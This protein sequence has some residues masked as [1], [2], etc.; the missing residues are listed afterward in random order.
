MAGENK[1]RHVRNMWDGLRANF[2]QLA[3]R[4]KAAPADDRPRTHGKTSKDKKHAAAGPG[5]DPREAVIPYQYAPLNE[6]AQEI[7]LLT[8]LPGNS[9]SHIRVCLHIKP[10]TKKTKLK[11]E[12]LSYSWG[13]QVDPVDIFV[14]KRGNQTIKVTQNLA[15]ALP[16]LRYPDKP[17]KLWIDAI[18]VNQQDP[19][20]R[21]S[22]VKRMADIYSMASQVVVWLGPEREDTQL[23]IDYCKEV[24]ANITVD[25]GLQTMAAAPTSKETHWVDRNEIVRWTPDQELAVCDLLK[26]DWFTRLWIWQ[27]VVLAT[28]VLVMCGLKCL[29]W[30]SIGDVVF[31]F[32]HKPKTPYAHESLFQVLESS[33]FLCKCEQSEN[34]IDLIDFT[35]DSMCSDPRDRLFALFSLLPPHQEDLA[36]EADYT[37][38]TAQVYL[39]FV[40]QYI[41]SKQ[42]LAILRFVEM[43]E[44]GEKG[45]MIS[46]WVPDW[47]S[48]PQTN[49]LH[50]FRASGLSKSST[51]FGEGGTLQVSG[52]N[53][54]DIECVESFSIQDSD[55]YDQLAMEL[56]RVTKQFLVRYSVNDASVNLLSLSRSLCGGEL[57]ELYLPLRK[58]YPTLQEA[59]EYLSKVLLDREDEPGD[60]ELTEKDMLVLDKI[61]RGCK[62]RNLFR[63]SNGT[64]GLA[65]KA[66]RPGDIVVAWLGFRNNMVL[67]CAGNGHYLLVGEAYCDGVMWGEAFLGS[68]PEQFQG[69]MHYNEETGWYYT[70]YIDR[71][72][73]EFY[74]AG[75]DPRLSDIPLPAGWT[76]KIY[77]DNKFETIFVNDETGDESAVD[78]RMNAEELKKRGVKLQEFI[79]E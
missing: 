39:E 6:E 57:F 5:L 56:A 29:D 42:D 66:A 33:Y 50:L 2:K 77:E 44:N 20:E 27:E 9:S 7:R 10:F 65:P 4:T 41:N 67:R 68:L 59:A 13:S 23:A 21:S 19:E 30:A 18:C 1:H 69:V 72:H 11:F 28:S 73:D 47:S 24:S 25:W 71:R 37:K 22:Q 36:I 12:A 63:C 31:S 17:R 78:P 58:D 26:R 45:S 43:G 51:S 38:S 35:K 75:E 60:L 74:P 34:F 49:R 32:Y 46:S 55:S 79:L 8:I 14:G 70:G 61:G 64:F 48:K 52:C 76:K 40:Q 54:G 16:C 15:H 3:S 62:G 53:I